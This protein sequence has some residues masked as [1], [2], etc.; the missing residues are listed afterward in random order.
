M[1]APRLLLVLLALAPR[2]ALAEEPLWATKRAEERT[3]A[4]A[5]LLAG[6]DSAAAIRSLNEAI[7]FDSTYAPAYLSLGRVH[8]S[9]GSPDRAEQAY[10]L[11]LERSPDV[12]ALRVAR[13]RLRAGSGQLEAAAS[14][15]EQAL[16]EGADRSGTLAT[17]V[18]VHVRAGLLPAA[19][20]ASRARVEVARRSGD[21][22][23]LA[24]E[25]RRARALGAL[26]RHVDPAVA[27]G[28]G[29]VRSAV[30]RFLAR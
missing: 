30:A 19:L 2:A 16:H 4:A 11:G 1:R 22:A 21:A 13:A 15:L 9:L 3:K 23:E 25:L 20:G 6:G 27:R 26:V 8:E 17:L 5:S 10:S 29:L 12:A 28:R 14:D 7:L 18:D 24:A